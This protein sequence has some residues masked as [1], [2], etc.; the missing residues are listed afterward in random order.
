MTLPLTGRISWADIANEI[1][2]DPNHRVG[3]DDPYLVAL[4]NN[5]RIDT[6]NLH[7]W[8]YRNDLLITLSDTAR[9][10]TPSNLAN[11]NKSFTGGHSN[12]RAGA[13]NVKIIV[14]SGVLIVSDSA[15]TPSL[16]VNGWVT[17]DD[18]H[19]DISGRVQGRGGTGGRYNP[20][21]LSTMWPNSPKVYA[22]DD[23]YVNGQ[24][25]GIA[26]ECLCPV[27]QLRILAGGTV[28]GGGG[29]G[30]AHM[31]MCENTYN[32]ISYSKALYY[33]TGGSGAGY[34]AA[35]AIPYTA[36]CK[37]LWN[38]KVRGWTDDQSYFRF[39]GVG[40]HYTLSGMMSVV[41]TAS[42]T[43]DQP[44]GHSVANTFFVTGTTKEGTKANMGREYAACGY[45]NSN[46]VESYGGALGAAPTVSER[47]SYYGA[48]FAGAGGAAV[49]GFSRIGVFTNAGTYHGALNG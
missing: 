13:T 6:L 11:L 5:G 1:Y 4:A 10:V 44:S 3:T 35:I 26:L 21:T 7:G 36:Y 40:S 29:G 16:T 28:A 15:L 41:T 30:I 48:A 46:L 8:T 34:G 32:Y 12:Y 43:L 47:G 38:A 37:G 31:H 45:A 25:G 17:G 39:N 19:I 23:S 20:G 2:A 24:S 22:R 49:A 14:P 42:A 27:T 18:V 33:R 9:S